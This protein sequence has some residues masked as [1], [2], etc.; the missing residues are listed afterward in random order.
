MSAA[1]KLAY[2]RDINDP[3]VTFCPD[4][5]LMRGDKGANIIEL[6]VMDGSSPADLSG[7]TA[8]VM[9]QRPGDSDRI[10]CP[11]SISGNVISVTL[12]GDCY[13]YSGQYY[14]S[15]VLDASG[16]TRT[17]LRLAGHVENNGDGPVVDPTGT[18]PGYEDIARIY[19][20]LEASLKRSDAAT[21]SANAA[22]QDANKKAALADAAAVSANNAAQNADQKAALADAAAESIDG[23]TVEASDV[24]YN[25]PATATVTDVEG[26]KHIAFGLRQGVPGAV[27]SITFTGETGEPN[28]DVVITQSG[29]P[30]APVVNLKI[31]QG[32]PGTGNVSSVDG[33]VSDSGGNVA[34][35]AVRY[36]AQTLEDAQKVQA[37]KN[38]GVDGQ[39]YPCTAAALEAMST[40]DLVN[41]YNQGYR[42]VQATNNETVV[43]LALAADGSLEWQGCN[44]DTTNLLDNP[45]F[46]I[47]QAGYG[48]LHG[49]Q[50]YAADRWKTV[51]VSDVSVAGDELTFSASAGYGGL[52]QCIRVENLPD[53]E[54]YTFSLRYRNGGNSDAFLLVSLAKDSGESSDLIGGKWFP[55]SHDDFS[56]AVYNFTQD[57]ISG[58]D[59]IVAKVQSVDVGSMTI[60]HPVLLPGSYTP[61]T[62]PPWES[63]DYTTELQKCRMYA[64]LSTASARYTGSG[65]ATTNIVQCYIPTG[66]KMRTNPTAY[67]STAINVSSRVQTGAYNDNDASISSVV[68]DVNGLLVQIAGSTQIINSAYANCTMNIN[69]G[70][71]FFADL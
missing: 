12:L 62:L 48:G 50:M 8:V 45:N 29:P 32:V 53:S 65:G 49:T 28:T 61:K 7:Y 41:I 39:I 71:G 40:A 57:Q 2:K 34:L 31:P 43:T 58:W 20:E 21:D 68:A 23:L 16:F 54:S 10:R 1:M 60:S 19:A 64:I 47:A 35:S 46:A 51:S 14:A 70:I 37:R 11:G 63:P 30:E 15:L 44:E 42:A 27:P 26:H 17:I 4:T 24:A 9:F 3:L 52:S 13:A 25:Q 22:A 6:T 5:L 33:V 18:I 56:T 36:V 55:S 66:V 69:S 38:I 67:P 59:M